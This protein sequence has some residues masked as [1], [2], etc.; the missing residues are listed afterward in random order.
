MREIAKF[1]KW[2]AFFIYYFKKRAE[3]EYNKIKNTDENNKNNNLRRIICSIYLYNYIKLK[4]N[5][6]KNLFKNKITPY[7]I[8]HINDEIDSR[9]KEKIGNN[10]SDFLKIEKYYLKYQPELD[11]GIKKILY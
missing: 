6:K 11:K 10:I 9:L 2:V 3:S 4:D 1:S 7:F 8:E 5:K